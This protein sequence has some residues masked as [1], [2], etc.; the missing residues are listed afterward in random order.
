MMFEIKDWQTLQTLLD[1]ETITLEHQ[2]TPRCV[3][4]AIA[5]TTKSKDHF[6]H[7][8]D[9]I[10]LDVCHRPNEGIHALK[11]CISTLANPYKFPN[12][13]TKETLKIMVLH[14]VVWYHK[15]QDWIHQQDQSQLTYQALLL[16]CQHLES[17]CEKLQKAK[18]NCH[19]ELT[20]L[21]AVTSSASCIH[22]DALSAYPKCP[23][24][25]YYHSPGNCPACGKECYRCSS[26]NNFT[27]LCQRR[28]QRSSWRNI[29]K[30]PRDAGTSFWQGHNQTSSRLKTGCSLKCSTHQ[31]SRMPSC[32][33][34]HS[35]SHSPTFLTEPVGTGDPHL[36][37]LP[38]Q[39]RDSPCV[40]HYRQPGDPSWLSPRRYPTVWACV[41]WS[42]QILHLASPDNQD[43]HKTPDSEARPQ[44]PGQHN[45]S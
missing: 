39:H 1:N 16:Q 9:K 29:A 26:H 4:D 38:V 23:Q 27:A 12:Q 7:F 8:W 25:C 13:N 37:Q 11:T 5:T 2:K 31:H 44:C 35:S 41:Q 33:P 6:W 18:E 22:Q 30:S 15:A 21:S 24:C 14:H 17:H 32:S 36:L 19:A 20:S 42:G 10:L 3:L 34:S 28:P 43:Q 45:T 40:I